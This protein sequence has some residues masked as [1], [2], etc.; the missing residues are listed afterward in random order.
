M[1][2]ARYILTALT[3]SLATLSHALESKPFDQTAFTQAQQAGKTTVLHF[4]ADWCPTCKKQTTSMAQLKSEK[5]LD[6]TV[7]V[8][9][10]D[11]EKQLKKK[12]G[13]RVQSTIIVFKGDVEKARLAG[14]TEV[15]DIKGALAKGL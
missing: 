4:H 14:Q 5:D 12:Y 8:A 10:Y 15:A 1:K 9:N 13:V 2:L 3:F 6:V 11:E 7:F